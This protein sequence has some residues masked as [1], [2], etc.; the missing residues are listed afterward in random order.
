MEWAPYF[1]YREGQLHCEAVALADLA[2]RFDTPLYVYSQ[3]AM[4]DRFALLRTAFGDSS[5]ICYA[6]KSNSNLQILKLF[7]DLGAGFDLVSGGELK[8]LQAVGLPSNQAV[9]AGVGK[10]SWEI[11]DALQA[12]LLF[13][14]VESEY[15]LALLEEQGKVLGRPI[16]VALRLNVDLDAGT[17]T[18]IATARKEDKFGL[19]LVTAGKLVRRIAASDSLD[20]VGYHVHLGSLLRQVSPYLEAFSR[21]EEFMDGEACRSE[22]LKYYDLGGGFGVSYGDGK[23]ILDVQDLGRQLLPRLAARGLTPVLE[24]GRFLT[25]DAGILL[26]KVLGSKSSGQHH[27]TLVDAAM[28]ELIRPALYGAKHPIAPVAESS[29]ATYPQDVV[30]PVCESGDFLAKAYPLPAMQRGDLLAVFAA[31]AYGFSMASNYNSRR[32][33]AEVLVH[34]EQVRP[35]RRRESFADLWAEE[36]EQ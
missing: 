36:L 8:R 12:G 34:G 11:R 27:F 20:L 9:F 19:D 26:C 14:N 35:I 10:E 16:Q 7:H 1:A 30:G 15:E 33:P 2:Q 3:Q 23:G 5:H 31:G 29:A 4:A 32:R 6:V 24:P 25:A 22:G 17:H 28:T 21:V 13:F 18:Y